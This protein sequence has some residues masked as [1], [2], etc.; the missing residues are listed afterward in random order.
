MSTGR[1]HWSNIAPEA[2]F[3][4]INASAS[5]P[6]LV[7]IL[8][9]RWITLAIAVVQTAFLHYLQFKKMTF[10]KFL[11]SKKTFFLGHSIRVERPLK[12]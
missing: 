10:G 9:P 11:K 8:F 6:W 7:L 3:F 1:Y 5:I 2:K 4:I 12:G